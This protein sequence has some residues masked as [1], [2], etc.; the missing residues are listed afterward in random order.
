MNVAQ[1]SWFQPIGN[2]PAKCCDCCLPAVYR[3]RAGIPVCD[4][5]KARYPD[6][7]PDRTPLTLETYP[8]AVQACRWAASMCGR[9]DGKPAGD[10]T[11]ASGWVPAEDAAEKAAQEAR[12]REER[13]RR[14]WTE[15]ELVQFEI[16][17]K[18]Q[19]RKRRT[20]EPTNE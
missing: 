17:L 18:E 2:G 1:N 5:C 14:T 19:F 20:D 16:D 12:E 11:E 15:A 10:F 7:A 4:G 3:T 9:T 13:A 6:P 8:Q